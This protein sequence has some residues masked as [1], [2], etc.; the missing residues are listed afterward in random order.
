MTID[1]I[2]EEIGISDFDL[3]RLIRKNY[4]PDNVFSKSELEQWAEENGY[5][6]E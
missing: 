1:D 4:F 2:C 5:T 6:K 3:L